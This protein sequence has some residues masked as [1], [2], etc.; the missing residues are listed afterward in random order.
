MDAK[1]T[2]IGY[3]NEILN[4]W[5][6][7]ESDCKDPNK[8]IWWLRQGS[9]EFHVELFS[10]PGRRGTKDCI[11]VSGKIMEIPSD[12]VKKQELYQYILEMNATGVGCWFAVRGKLVML[13]SNRE[14]EGLDKIEFRSMIDDVRFYSDQFDDI[15]KEKYGANYKAPGQ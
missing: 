10:N 13:I 14:I 12:P 9:A 2:A 7:P 3:I 15:F 8:D 11:E 4:E 5:G 1:Q 6:V